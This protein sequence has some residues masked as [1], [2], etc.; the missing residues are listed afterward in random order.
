M[1]SEVFWSHDKIYDHFSDDRSVFE[2]ACELLK[3]TDVMDKT[4]SDVYINKLPLGEATEAPFL[5][6]FCTL[7]ED[8]GPPCEN[9]RGKTNLGCCLDEMD[10]SRHR[11][12]VIGAVLKGNSPYYF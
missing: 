5:V 10:A 3:E 8:V 4:V 7:F 6:L 9:Q 11:R 1:V 2:T 12:E